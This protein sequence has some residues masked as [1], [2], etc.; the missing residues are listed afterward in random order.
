MLSWIRSKFGPL[1]VGAIIGLIAFVFVASDLLNPRATRGMHAGAVAAQVNG[2]AITLSEF[3]REYN[4]RLE[5]FKNMA[6][7][8][9]TPEQLKQFRLKEGVLNELVQRKLM[10]QSAAKWG[11]EVSDEELKDRIKEIPAFSKDVAGVKTF[12]PLL[13]K[14]VLEA[15]HY[16][17]GTFEQMMREDLR[18]QAWNQFFKGRAKVSDEEVKREFMVNHDKRGLRYVFIDHEN[19]KKGVVIA[20]ADVEK[21]LKDP[22]RANVV[23]NQY[24]LKTNT[25]F[26]GKKLEDVQNM[27]AWTAQHL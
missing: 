5:F 1:V 26:K 14:Q 9:V 27:A 13:Y 19:A 7:G 23:K 3:N 6:G 24:E 12:D 21:Y 18:L 20:D 16:A 8:K 17:P 15:N 2:E 11:M 25:V 22:S 4:R 10:S